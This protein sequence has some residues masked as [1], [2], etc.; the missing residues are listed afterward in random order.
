MFRR[1]VQVFTIISFMTSCAADPQPLTSSSSKNPCGD[2]KCLPPEEPPAENSTDPFSAAAE[3]CLSCLNVTS[4]ACLD[5]F[6]D[7]SM[8]L[9]CR[10]WKDCNTSCVVSDDESTCYEVC[11]SV[12]QDFYTPEKLKSC[13]CEVCFAQCF[14]MCPPE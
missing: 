12:V 2:S 3:E 5:E 6:E 13:S 14:N 8:S 9:A 4:T 10:S 1:T 7:C 11:D